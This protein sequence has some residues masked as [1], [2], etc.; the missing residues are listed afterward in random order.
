[1]AG[2]EGCPADDQ[3]PRRAP[4]I[5]S[6][7]PASQAERRAVMNDADPQLGDEVWYVVH[8]EGEVIAGPFTDA[9]TAQRL[10]EGFGPDH[11]VM[12]G[13]MLGNPGPH[14]STIP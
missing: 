4:E 2:I 11:V 5:E 6:V 8:G 12:P 7:F 10:A 3:V 13:T 1:V 9:A 14:G